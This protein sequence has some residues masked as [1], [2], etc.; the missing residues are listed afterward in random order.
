M[1]HILAHDDIII[2]LAFHREGAT[3]KSVV[4]VWNTRVISYN[5]ML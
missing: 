1:E 2:V 3:V 4:S 5:I